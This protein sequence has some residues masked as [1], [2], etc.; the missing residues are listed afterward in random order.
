VD[1]HSGGPEPLADVMLELEPAASNRVRLDPPRRDRWG[2]PGVV[3]RSLWTGRDRR[4]R[5]RALTVL[6]DLAT[7]LGEPEAA[8][9]A[10]RW[11][12]PAGVC[13]M[14][15][16]ARRGVVDPH[17]RVFGLSNLHVAG[18]SVFP[19]SGSTNPTL[20]IV[21]LALRLGDELARRLLDGREARPR[22]R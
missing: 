12:H 13:R 19:T 10:E 22:R 2:R 21:A 1:V 5:D 14:A 6:R 8:P 15:A 7:S 20:T 9:P 11:F 3:L 17:G 4:T 16:D 18:A